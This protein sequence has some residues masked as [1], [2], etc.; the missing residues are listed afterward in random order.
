MILECPNCEVTYEIPVDLPPEGR[1]VR[2]AS[3]QHIWNATMADQPK[4]D[5]ALPDFDGEEI[6]FKE[7]PEASEEPEPA[8]A[9]PEASAE[10]VAEPE[11]DDEVAADFDFDSIPVDEPDAETE[12]AEDPVA[13]A[14]AEAEAEAEAN[15]EAEGKTEET[16]VEA[17]TETPA[18]E[19]P[20]SNAEAGESGTEPEEAESPPIVIGKA[21]K[22]RG[23]MLGNIAAGWAALALIVTSITGFAYFQ[24]ISVVR[25]LSGT[26]STYESIGLP[27]NVRGLEFEKVKYSWE[28]SAGR[29]VLEVF[30]D[31]VNVTSK[32]M[33]VPT[34]V[35]GLRTKEKVEV[36]QWAADVRSEL[37]PPGKSTAFSA[38]IPSPPKSIRD[39]QVRFAKV[40]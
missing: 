37:L 10:E 12:L 7:G 32:P 1:K 2:C 29:P 4:P 22:R 6:V 14:V 24:R 15:K 20:E 27:V 8:A 16:V 30:G 38:Q 34:V 5:I 21:R 31:I 25:V 17:A 3:C 9:E 40:R 36:Y 19:E 18:D 23:P 35:F 39:V 33:K 26:A 28:T 13:E 11:L